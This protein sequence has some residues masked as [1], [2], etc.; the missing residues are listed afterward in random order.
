[1][2]HLRPSTGISIH[3]S[4][5]RLMAHCE[6]RPTPGASSSRM[7]RPTRSTT[8]IRSIARH[9]YHPWCLPPPQLSTMSHYFRVSSRRTHRRCS[10]ARY[11]ASALRRSPLLTRL[12]RRPRSVPPIKPC[13]RLH[14][15][16]PAPW[17]HRHRCPLQPSRLLARSPP[18]LHQRSPSL[19]RA[20]QS[21]S[22]SYLRHH[23]RCC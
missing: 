17:L 8:S 19:P 1:M 16:H 11:Y 15:N 4:L 20:S 14:N 21:F 7:S 23:C 13:R 5:E 10:E 22:H 6:S 9:Q 3:C 18:P 2:S 12:F